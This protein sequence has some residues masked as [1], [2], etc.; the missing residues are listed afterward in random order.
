MTRAGGRRARDLTE[1]AAA[2]V[3]AAAAAQVPTCTHPHDG[4]LY[5]KP[6]EPQRHDGDCQMAQHTYVH[7]GEPGV[8]SHGPT[9]HY[10]ADV[11]GTNGRR[12]LMR[13]DPDGLYVGGVLLTN[14]L[15]IDLIDELQVMVINRRNRGLQ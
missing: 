3:G 4:M 5:E 14:E 12:L 1:L 8:Y 2:V 11:V 10:A 7:Q 9:P 15:A 6:A 13:D